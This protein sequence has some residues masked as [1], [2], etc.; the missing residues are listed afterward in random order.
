MGIYL[1]YYVRGWY[2]ARN[3]DKFEL[4]FL[5]SRNWTVPVLTKIKFTE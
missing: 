2:V 3:T 4:S 1:W 5:L